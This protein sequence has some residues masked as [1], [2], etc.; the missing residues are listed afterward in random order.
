MN[1]HNYILTLNEYFYIFN[2]SKLEPL[3]SGNW[4]LLSVHN[5]S[6]SKEIDPVKLDV[7][8]LSLLPKSNHTFVNM[9]KIKIVIMLL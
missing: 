2:L 6:I 4:T 9:I 1:T 8:V 7:K 5:H 3:T